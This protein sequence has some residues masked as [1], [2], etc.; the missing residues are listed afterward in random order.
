MTAYGESAWVGLKHFDRLFTSADFLMILR[1]TLLLNIYSVVFAFPVPILLAI[2]LNE[3]RSMA[4]KRVTQSLLYLP[5]FISWVVLGGIFIGLL[6]PS[7][8]VVNLLL[9]KVSI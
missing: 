2:L 1:N 5:H 9:N 6:S 8:G 4:F 7:T 3:V